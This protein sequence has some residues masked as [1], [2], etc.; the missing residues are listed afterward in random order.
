MSDD[1]DWDDTRVMPRIDVDPS[2]TI[3][4]QLPQED[5]DVTLDSRADE[6]LI[7]TPSEQLA[8]AAAIRTAMEVLR[9]SPFEPVALSDVIRLATWLLYGV[10]RVDA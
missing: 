8:R 7:S 5:D 10:D 3:N 6:T 9:D 4:V 2:P 1:A